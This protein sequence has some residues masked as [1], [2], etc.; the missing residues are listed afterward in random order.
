MRNVSRGDVAFRSIAMLLLVIEKDIGPVGLEKFTFGQPAE[1]QRLVEVL[2]VL[3]FRSIQ[4]ISPSCETKSL[5]A[6]IKQECGE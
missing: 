6:G 3:D 5:P 2:H 1:K 4:P